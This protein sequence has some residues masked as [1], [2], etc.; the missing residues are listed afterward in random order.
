[1]TMSIKV[2]IPSLVSTMSTLQQ[3]ELN[4]LEMYVI[5]FISCE[6]QH[7]MQ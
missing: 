6:S 1:M 5:V 2:R 3:E 4:M 7:L